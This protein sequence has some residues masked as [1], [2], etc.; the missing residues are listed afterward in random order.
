M[1]KLTR[2]G[3]TM[4]TLKEKD[5]GAMSKPSKISEELKA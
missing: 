2:Y 4:L 1:K 3:P 5:G